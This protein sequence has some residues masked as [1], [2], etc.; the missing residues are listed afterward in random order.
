MR[1]IDRL[2][3]YRDALAA[4]SAYG[5]GNGTRADEARWHLA[6]AT[7]EVPAEVE[8]LRSEAA[9]LHEAGFEPRAAQLRVGADELADFLAGKPDPA[10]APRRTRGRR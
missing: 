5:N 6:E 3:H 2:R 9:E 8:R 4:L 1:L 10:P 7:A